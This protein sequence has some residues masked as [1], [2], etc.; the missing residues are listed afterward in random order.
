MI[1]KC[2]VKRVSKRRVRKTTRPKRHKRGQN[3]IKCYLKAL[4]EAREFFENDLKPT[5]L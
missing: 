5:A 3:A 2:F 1:L 4:K